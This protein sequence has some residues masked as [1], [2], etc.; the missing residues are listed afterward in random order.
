MSHNFEHLGEIMS[1]IQS[2]TYSLNFTQ[3]FN[4]SFS[5]S[6]TKY[7]APRYFHNIIHMVANKL[8]SSKNVMFPD[9]VYTLEKHDNGRMHMHGIFYLKCPISSEMLFN[10]RKLVYDSI[11]GLCSKKIG[12][13]K[14]AF[15]EKEQKSKEFASYYDYMIKK[16]EIDTEKYIYDV[17]IGYKEP[18][19]VKY[20]KIY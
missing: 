18:D 5:D 19:I 7:N 16:T 20:Y 4:R 11:Q 15:N 2:A 14:I 10:E 12:N 8:L 9:Y 3:T 17:R 13:L 1:K 6:D